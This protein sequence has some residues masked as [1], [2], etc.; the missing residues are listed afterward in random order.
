[1]EDTA[2]YLIHADVV[3]D[4][5]VERSDVVGAVFGQTEGLLGD[6]LD[7][8][9]LQE[10]SRLGRIDVEVE[11][12]GGQSF[13]RIT[14]ASSLD[15]VET[16][17]LAAALEAIERVGP[18]MARVEVARIEDVRAAKR[19]RV[20]DRA[21]E[22]L[23]TKFDEGALDSA[24][25]VSEV[26]ESIKVEDITEFHGLPAGPHVESSD[27]VVVVE[28][29]ADVN[30]LLRYGIKN[31]VAVEGTN[32]PD[33]VAE[34]TREKHATAF[35]DGDRGG[36]L[37]LRELAQVGDVDAVA[38]APDGKSVEDLSREEV[39]AALRAKTPFESVDAHTDAS[40]EPNDEA[41]DEPH[42]ERDGEVSAG[43]AADAD[44]D[45]V[46]ERASNPT[47]AASTGGGVEAELVAR[48]R[49]SEPGESDAT[50]ADAAD[51]AASTA[52]ENAS[53]STPMET[54]SPAADAAEA[55]ESEESVDTAGA[56]DAAAVEPASEGEEPVVRSL[57]DVVADVA[58]SGRA[59][60]LDAD[61]DTVSEGAADEAF[62]LVADSTPHVVVLDAAVPQR[63]LDVAAQRDVGVVVG[64]SEG[65]YV[66]QPAGVRVHTHGDF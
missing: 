65:E 12:E 4:G 13:G 36:E 57:G 27:A 40:D 33:A 56:G 55:A 14:I 10:S 47:S 37:I 39:H 11:S 7:I 1:M 25:I 31:A 8:H 41:G 50:G 21:K 64:A 24:D 43:D 22:L 9:D 18:C 66:K 49:P 38:H 46:G 54:E 45:A 26:R 61:L 30:Q 34:L 32:V 16:A 29:R 6:D 53:E 51:T 52:S 35:L 59:V 42:D 20:V 19:R 63:L 60:C 44:T 17:I 2:K 62:D 58:G 28:G 23:N 3:A 15:R 48:T 5:V